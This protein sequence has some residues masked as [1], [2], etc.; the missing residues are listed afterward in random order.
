MNKLP[1]LT[2]EERNAALKRA[3][4]V[5]RERAMLKSRLK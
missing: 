4:Q 2:E 1:K 5:R 3:M